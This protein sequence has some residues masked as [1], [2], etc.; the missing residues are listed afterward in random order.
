MWAVLI[1]APRYIAEISGAP[2]VSMTPY[3]PDYVRQGVRGTDSLC[4]GLLGSGALLD[5]DG[6]RRL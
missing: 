4:Q 2:R 6:F 1:V 5:L 3:D